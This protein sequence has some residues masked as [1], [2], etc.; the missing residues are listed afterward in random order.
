[1]E[2]K[3]TRLISILVAILLVATSVQTVMATDSNDLY[4]SDVAVE[5]FEN[6]SDMGSDADQEPPEEADDSVSSDV[7]DEEMDVYVNDNNNDNNNGNDDEVDDIEEDIV[8]VEEDSITSIDEQENNLS[9][10]TIG[11]G[12]VEWTLDSEG[13]VRVSGGTVNIPHNQ[14]IQPWFDTN[15]RANVQR[16]IF[17]EN[18]TWIGSMTG[19]FYWLPHL[20][21]IE[22]LNLI[23]TSQVTSMNHTFSWLHNVNTLDIYNWSTSSLITM[24]SMFGIGNCVS[25]LPRVLV[26]GPNFHFVGTNNIGNLPSN[27][28][29]TGMWINVGGGTIENPQGPH[30]LSS[31]EL[32]ADFDGATMAGTWVWQRRPTTE[33]TVT[34]DGNQGIVLSENAQRSVTEPTALGENMPNNPEREGYSFTGWNTQADGNG[35]VFDANTLVTA[36]LTVYAQWEAVEVWRIVVRYLANHNEETDLSVV[37]TTGGYVVGT[38]YRIKN[39]TAPYKTP[40]FDLDG[41][42]FTGW[43]TMRDGTGDSLEYGELVTLTL[44]II[45]EPS[46][47]SE[48]R[49]Y[50]Q[51][52]PVMVVAQPER[53][54]ERRPETRPETPREIAPRTGDTA[55]QLILPSLAIA[56]VGLYGIVTWF[57]S[58]RRGYVKRH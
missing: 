20:H 37:H 13:V 7:T 1:M 43:N 5:S 22:G 8:T 14:S 41:H 23:D 36:N 11:D 10:G 47:N 54:P 25:C 3:A 2:R 15:I 12:G 46:L 45:Q 51:W 42:N 44:R 52:E 19:L 32:Q 34:F 26:L 29:Y 30:V 28:T 18:I 49:L 35:T 50:A 17:T 38:S 53:Q 31:A 56:L 39:Y 40:E 24:G 57:I 27:E 58:K 21:T 48:F 9:S 4:E 33:F 6:E 16:I 55:S